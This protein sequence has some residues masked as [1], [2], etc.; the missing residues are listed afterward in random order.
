MKIRIYY[1]N[2][3]ETKLVGYQKLYNQIA[4]HIMESEKKEGNYEVSVT[5]VSEEDI[6]NYNRDYRNIDRVTDVLSFALQEGENYELPKGMPIQL[7]DILIC[8]KRAKEQAHNYGHSIKREMAFL[9]THGML[10]LLGYDHMNEKDEK[11][12]FKKQER[13]LN[14]LDIRR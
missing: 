10:H 13:I 4:K 2:S 6:Q 1:Q 5:I 9:F 12:M 14:D 8:Y 11:V 3:I 7:G